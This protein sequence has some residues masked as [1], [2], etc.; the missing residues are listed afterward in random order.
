MAKSRSSSA[1]PRSKAAIGASHRSGPPAGKTLRKQ[2]ASSGASRGGREVY[3][4][5]GAGSGIGRHLAG[6][7]ARQGREL[8]LTDV[9]FAALESL[10]DE[11]SEYPIEIHELDVRSA[12]AWQALIAHVTTRHGR[13]DAVLNIAGYIR[14]GYVHELD[15]EEVD[16]HIDINVKGVIFGTRYAAE[17]MAARKQGHI[18]NFASLAGVAPIA[19]IGVYSASKHAVRGFSL[20][21]AEELQ[22]FNVAVTAV[23]PDAVATP[24]LDKQVAFKEAAL[25]FSGSR[26]LTVEDIERVI[27]KRVLPKRPREA[28]IPGSR[29]ALAK[30]GGAFPSLAKLL[31]RTLTAK[32]DARR[33]SLQSTPD[34]KPSDRR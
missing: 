16:R 23:C 24:M 4:L 20:A 17:Y 19:G 14:P 7:F 26:F 9:N 15:P 1:R 30:I 33:R 11:L 12:R 22:A 10:A 25:T 13:L 34:A 5:T 3:L 27:V 28:L 18:I 32:G 31:S 29:G 6:V 21:A 2:T 8:I